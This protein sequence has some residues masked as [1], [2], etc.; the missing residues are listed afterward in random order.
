LVGIDGTQ[1]FA[2]VSD[3]IEKK[4]QRLQLAEPLEDKTE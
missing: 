4:V 2:A 3:D 1:L